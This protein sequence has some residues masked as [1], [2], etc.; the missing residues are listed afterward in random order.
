MDVG[1]RYGLTDIGI[2]HSARHSPLRNGATPDRRT[3]RERPLLRRRLLV[4]RS[5]VR[6]R[7]RERER[8]SRWGKI[9]PSSPPQ[10]VGCCSTS[11][12]KSLF[13]LLLLLRPCFSSRKVPKAVSALGG[14]TTTCRS[15]T[16]SAGCSALGWTAAQPLVG[17]FALC[18]VR[19]PDLPDRVAGF[20]HPADADG[21]DRV[22]GALPDGWH[23]GAGLPDLWLCPLGTDRAQAVI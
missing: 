20:V 6:P 4:R 16:T 12:G 2:S 8:L 23:L 11:R 10:T 9:S 14:A 18:G 22:S 17:A 7:D 13:T 15:T 19:V 1:H 5:S 3:R 21:R